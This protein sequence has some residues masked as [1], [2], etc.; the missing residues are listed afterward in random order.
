MKINFLNSSQIAV[1]FR[2]V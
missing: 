2:H 1:L